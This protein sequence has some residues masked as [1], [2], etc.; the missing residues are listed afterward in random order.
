[1]RKEKLESVIHARDVSLGDVH[2]RKLAPPVLLRP[3]ENISFRHGTRLALFLK[4]FGFYTLIAED[5]GN[6]GWVVA[7]SC[8]AEVTDDLYSGWGWGWG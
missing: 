8:R 4:R 1:M 5:N 6:P 2:H 7:W 3:R